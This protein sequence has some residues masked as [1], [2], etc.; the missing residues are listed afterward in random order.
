LKAIFFSL[1]NISLR[2]LSIMR[3]STTVSRWGI[4]TQLLSGAGGT[5]VGK[6]NTARC[7]QGPQ[8]GMPTHCALPVWSPAKASQHQHWKVN[9]WSLHLKESFYHTVSHSKFCVTEHS[10]SRNDLF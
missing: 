4:N 2:Y 1:H 8:W 3:N 5:P 7:Y 9:L 10:L 6:P